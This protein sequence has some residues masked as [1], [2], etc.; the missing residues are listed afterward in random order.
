MSEQKPDKA[1]AFADAVTPA[2]LEGLTPALTKMLAE[3]MRALGLTGLFDERRPYEPPRD[4]ALE[5]RVVSTVWEGVAPP[6]WLRAEHFYA[7]FYAKLFTF[8]LEFL[9]NG[10]RPT[11]EAAVEWHTA[12]GFASH[13]REAIERVIGKPAIVPV[14]EYAR[15]LVDL[16]AQRET[17]FRCERAVA[18]LRLAR[19]DDASRAEIRAELVAAL[20]A[21]DGKEASGEEA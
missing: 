17:M 21:F 8:A 11:V 13:V 12:Q 16:A 10:E 1:K 3:E 20:D 14:A 5:Q 15:R 2:L 4:L 6:E 9:K 7:P 18:L 19:T